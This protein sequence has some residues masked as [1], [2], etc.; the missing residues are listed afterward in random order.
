MR[1]S[2]RKSARREKVVGAEENCKKKTR[3][4]IKLLLARCPKRMTP[5]PLLPQQQPLDDCNSHRMRPRLTKAVRLIIKISMLFLL[6]LLLL[7]L[8]FH[9][10]LDN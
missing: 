10:A 4:M 2:K 8:T 5:Q 9:F 7:Q 6:L 3:K 1:N